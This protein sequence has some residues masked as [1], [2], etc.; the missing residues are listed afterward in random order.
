[1]AK[2]WNEITLS[3]E[4]K[5]YENKNDFRNKS[6]WA[7]LVAQELGIYDKITSHMNR[8]GGWTKEEAKLEASKYGRKV[9]FK[10][11]NNKLWQFAKK[12]D[13]YE[14]ICSHM[15]TVGNPKQKLVYE[16]WFPSAVYV[17]VTD[18]IEDR[19]IG[20]TIKG[21]VF[22]Y[23]Q[24]TGES[25]EIKLITDYIY[26]EDAGKLEKKL[27]AQYK[28]EGY[29]V[30]N[31]T[32]GGELGLVEEYWT[33]EKV[34]ELSKTYKF[35]GQFCEEHPVPYNKAH[36]N[37]WDEV[38]SHMED[39]LIDWDEEKIIKAAKD[40]GL[41]LI[42]EFAKE[43]S[44]AYYAAKRLGIQQK[45]RDVFEWKGGKKWTKEEILEIAK[46][47]TVRSQFGKEHKNAS[48]YAQDKGW[49]E[50]ITS[51]MGYQPKGKKWTKKEV[52]EEAKKYKTRTEFARSSDTKGCNKAYQSALHNGWLDEVCSHMIVAKGGKI[53]K[54]K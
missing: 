27:I 18:D 8:R 11:G 52:H 39:K 2:K 23:Q 26:C 53:G 34:M 12:Q 14:E 38:F 9:D 20:H 46:K 30:L 25:P 13:Y 31:K 22:D 15:R 24:K 54:R 3:E 43:Y 32:K 10:R 17:G 7:V 47:Y 36:K 21:S 48:W 35:R 1:M 44:G 4:A 41:N 29:N 33:K 37:N 16:Y 42:T 5:K 51:H 40:C 6:S 49:Y 45:L 50:E 19:K 28:E